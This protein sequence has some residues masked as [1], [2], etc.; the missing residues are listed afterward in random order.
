MM[1]RVRN[2]NMAE[3]NDQLLSFYEK[4]SSHN[5]MGKTYRL[6]YQWGEIAVNYL[7]KN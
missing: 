3:F 2:M 7:V 4:L 6:I 1:V 5:G